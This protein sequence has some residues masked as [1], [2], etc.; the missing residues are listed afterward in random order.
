L[1]QYKIRLVYSTVI[2]YF[3]LIY[4]LLTSILFSVIIARELSPKEFGLWGVILSL[5]TTLSTPIMIWVYWMQRY[6]ARGFKRAT[7]TGLILT[8]AYC[9]LAT[10]IYLYLIELQKNIFG[11]DVRHLVW[12]VPFLLL[13]LLH[14]Y[15]M[16][17][18]SVSKP[19]LRGFCISV[20]NT[21]RLCVLALFLFLGGSHI[22]LIVVIMVN[23]FALLLSNIYLYLSLILVGALNYSFDLN[24]VLEWFKGSFVPGFNTVYNMLSRYIRVAVSW[25]S[26]SEAPAAYLNI[27]FSSGAP[28]LQ[29]SHAAM[30]ALYAKI[31]REKRGGDVENAFR[32]F[33]ILSGFLFPSLILLSKPIATLYNPEYLEAHVLVELFTVYTLILGVQNLCFVIIQGSID[34]DRYGIGSVRQV[35]KSYLVKSYLLKLIGIS[36]A[37]SLIF[38]LI[39]VVKEDYLLESVIAIIALVIGT[40][41]V[42]PFFYRIASQNVSYRLPWREVKASIV[43]ACFIF[44]YYTL[45][46]ARN[47]VVT[48]LLADSQILITHAVVALAIYIATEYVLSPWTRRIINKELGK[49]LKLSE[50]D[51]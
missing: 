40:L 50:K 20:Y 28:L 49:L 22:D 5:V 19:E 14:N 9:S 31:L 27:A 24:L 8:L 46:G 11:W 1:S 35:L 45:S 13:N 25:L 34:V 30:P 42:L 51:L 15:G 36:I 7:G 4:R 3:S 48:N 43:A 6:F 10:G 16:S 12:G 47:V 37:Y 21:L 41:A 39:P 18:A 33:V 29:T 26:G 44:I 2:N 38:A 32:L 23:A 17:V